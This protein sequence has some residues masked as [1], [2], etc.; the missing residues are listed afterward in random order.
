[1]K[2]LLTIPF[3][4]YYNRD[5]LFPFGKYNQGEIAVQKHFCKIAMQ[6]LNGTFFVY[7]QNTFRFPHAVYSLNNIDIFRLIFTYAPQKQ[8]YNPSKSNYSCSTW[9]FLMWN[10]ILLLTCEIKRDMILRFTENRSNS[11]EFSF[12][13]NTYE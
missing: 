10:M 6:Q 7:K 5:F 13:W 8:K 12:C 4:H 11:A 2:N 3:R 1:M 9:Y